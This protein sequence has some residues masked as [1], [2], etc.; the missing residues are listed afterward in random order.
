M[1]APMP[2]PAAFWV[3]PAGTPVSVLDRTPGLHVTYHQGESKHGPTTVAY[4]EYAVPER[5]DRVYGGR[6]RSAMNVIA[7]DVM[8]GALYA[9]APT[10]AHSVAL[11]DAMKPAAAGPPGD[12]L[13]KV[14]SATAVYVD[15][16]WLTAIPP[17]AGQF[18]SFVWADEFISDVGR[19]ALPRSASRPGVAKPVARP[20]AMSSVSFQAKTGATG[21]K[22]LTAQ[23][24]LSDPSKRRLQGLISGE[25]LSPDSIK[26]GRKPILTVVVLDYL[27]RQVGYE[28]VLLPDG[29]DRQVLAFNAAIETMIKLLPGAGNGRVFALAHLDGTVTPPIVFEPP[30]SS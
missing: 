13:S 22:L 9:N 30:K 21:S 2:V 16:P 8:N 18:T 6:A 3:D 4:I 10:S 7:I 5:H 15:I 1:A 17:E 28:S 26:N 23:A 19:F 20:S 24:D 25:L 29:A 11:A 27:T 12:G 14:T